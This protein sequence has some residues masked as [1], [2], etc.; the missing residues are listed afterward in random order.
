MFRE[1]RSYQSV[2][3][4][5]NG[6]KKFFGRYTLAEI[7]PALIDEFKQRR[8]AAGVKPATINRQLNIFRRMFN[9][10]KKRW[11]WIKEIPI[12]EMEAKADQKE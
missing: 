11:M 2:Q 12:I 5:L 3:G 10:A 7:T 8:K 6:L 4:Y 1:T 9:I